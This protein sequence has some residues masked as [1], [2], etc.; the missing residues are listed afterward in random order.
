M[1][2]ALHGGKIPMQCFVFLKLVIQIIN[3]ENILRF[4]FKRVFIMVHIKKM[5][6][7]KDRLSPRTI[8]II[9]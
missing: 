2:K 8:A 9:I 7:G 3:V 6:N 1:N 4:H 5:K